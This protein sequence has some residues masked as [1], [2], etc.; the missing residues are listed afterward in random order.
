[1]GY[2]NKSLN[3]GFSLKGQDFYTLDLLGLHRCAQLQLR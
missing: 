2:V 1:M 3:K